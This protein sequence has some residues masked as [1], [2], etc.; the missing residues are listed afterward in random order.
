MP[1]TGCRRARILAT[2]A[3]LRARSSASARRRSSSRACRA[4]IS[5]AVGWRRFGVPASLP[6]SVLTRRRTSSPLKC[7]S[8]AMA[9]PP[10]HI[11]GSARCSLRARPRTCQTPP[12]RGQGPTIPGLLSQFRAVALG[13]LRGPELRALGGV[14]SSENIADLLLGGRAALGKLSGNCGIHDQCLG[15]CREYGAVE[16]SCAGGLFT[17]R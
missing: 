5:S 9:S 6:I 8:S 17:L 7:I 16:R 2:L 1:T 10:V 3:A 4:A 11:R 12:Q 13:D 14:S 15:L